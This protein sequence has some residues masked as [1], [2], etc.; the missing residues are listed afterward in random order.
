MTVAAA[1]EFAQNTD[2]STAEGAAILALAGECA[3]LAR[4]GCVSCRWERKTP[5]FH[6]PFCGKIYDGCGRIV[7]CEALGWMCGA[8]EH[9]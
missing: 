8:H 4:M 1:L 7:G 3:A 2:G 9:E 5:I 6:D